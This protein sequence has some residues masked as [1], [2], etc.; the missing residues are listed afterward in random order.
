MMHAPAIHLVPLTRSDLARLVQDDDEFARSRELQLGAVRDATIAVAEQSARFY[1]ETGVEAPWGAYLAV[2]D[3]DAQVVGFGSFKGQ[4][5]DEGTVEIAY[6]TFP[7]YEGRGIASA[8][9]AQLVAIARRCT[10]VEVV[11]AHTLR[12]ENASVRLLRRL[13]FEL[14]GEVIDDPADGV[15]WRWELAARPEADVTA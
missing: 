4:P 3:T 7:P 5:R 11:V 1:D 9:A 10:D 14:V 6:A 2:G 12:E 8:I 15:V 13:G